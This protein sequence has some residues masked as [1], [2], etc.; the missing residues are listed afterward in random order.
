MEMP[1]K[2]VTLMTA[3]LQARDDL[4]LRTD[5]TAKA[6]SRQQRP[7]LTTLDYS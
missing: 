6:S 3:M 2:C 7:V 5:K 1:T 4:F